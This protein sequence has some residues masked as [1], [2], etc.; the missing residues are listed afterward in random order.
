MRHGASH[1]T[2]RRAGRRRTWRPAATGRRVLRSQRLRD[3]HAS[4]SAGPIGVDVLRAGGQAP[5]TT[6][7]RSICRP[8]PRRCGSAA[9]RRWRGP[10]SIWRCA[11]SSRALRRRAA[12]GPNAP[13]SL[14]RAR[15]LSSAGAP[16]PKAQGSGRPVA[17]RSRWSRAVDVARAAAHPTGRRSAAP[18]AVTAGEWTDRRDLAPGEVWD[19][20]VPRHPPTGSAPF[21]VATAARVSSLRGGPVE[22]RHAPAGRVG[23]SL[24]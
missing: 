20:D 10:S 22:H 17:E 6:G 14:R 21:T 12:C 7:A 8:A 3:G 9:M 5:G 2:A 23:R 16:G 1:R 18:S 15:S 4:R 19:L 11:W 13:S 24:R